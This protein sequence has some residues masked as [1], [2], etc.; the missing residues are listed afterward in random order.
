MRRLIRP[1]FYLGQNH[2]SQFGVALTTTSA[3]TLLTMYFAEFF[4]TREGPYT[5]IIAFFGL[6]ALFLLGLLMIPAGIYLRYRQQRASGELP[7]EYPRVDFHDAHLRET[8]G[9]IVLMTAVNM[10]LMLTATYK[11]VNYMDSTQFCGQTCHTPMTP[12]YTAYQGSP[13]SRVGCTECHVGQGFTGFVEAKVAGTRQLAGVFFNNYQRPIP[14]PV[15]TLRPARET[16]EHCHWPQ[17]FTG[18]YFWTH[19]KYSDDEKNSPLTTVL[20]LKLG[21]TTWQGSVGIH[22]RHLDTGKSRIEYIS[23]DNARQVIPDVHYVDD[24]GQSVV[25][26][27]SEVKATPEQLAHGEHRSMDCVD[28]H[29]RPTHAFQLPERAVDQ[30]MSE[31]RISTDLPF[32][33]KKSV[34]LLKVAYPDQDT[35]AQRILAGINDYYKTSYPAVYSG[36]RSQVEAAADQVKAIYLRNV[37]P[38]MKI[39]W[40]THPNNI[41]HD[42]YLG[43]FR[44]HDG[45]HTT[46]DGK[47]ITNECTA[48]HNLLAVDD[49]NPKIL[50]DMG[51]KK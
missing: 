50:T 19:T 21:G 4:G 31:G 47:T 38:E 30:A 26:A 18:D 13:H 44:C 20:V 7:S 33:K 17:R 12:E 34:E 43:C 16:C 5:G 35:A 48:C 6:P 8:A 3:F 39:T 46:K 22:G 28:C 42:D 2:L 49:P 23:T 36:H 51:L 29:N 14:S 1:I 37:F 41:G 11:A 27:S 25:Y 10:V 15:R 24:Q 40:G 45:N 9:F 32:I